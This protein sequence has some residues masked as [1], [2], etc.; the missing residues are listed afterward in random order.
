MSMLVAITGAVVTLAAAACYVR[1][2]HAG[3]DPRN[4]IVP[5][6]ESVVPVLKRED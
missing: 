2:R 4:S 3:R 1:W 6:R 5:V